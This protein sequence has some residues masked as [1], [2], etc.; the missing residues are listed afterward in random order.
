MPT[1]YPSTSDAACGR[2]APYPFR[3]ASVDVVPAPEC[4]NL[5]LADENIRWSTKSN[6][7]ILTSL[8][9]RAWQQPPVA[10]G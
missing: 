3:P 9:T 2:S 6:S 5:G 10:L 7:A 4:V 8:M 1:D